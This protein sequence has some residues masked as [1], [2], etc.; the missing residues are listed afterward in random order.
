MENT[1]D[2]NREQ[3]SE[4]CFQLAFYQEEEQFIDFEDDYFT[5]DI[6]NFF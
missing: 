3:I 6:S 2:F 5:D 4:R 1:T